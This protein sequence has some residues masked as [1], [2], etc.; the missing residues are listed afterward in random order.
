MHV[1][2]VDV[3]IQRQ[4]RLGADYAHKRLQKEQLLTVVKYSIFQRKSPHIILFKTL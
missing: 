3:I 1:A 2:A 4:Y